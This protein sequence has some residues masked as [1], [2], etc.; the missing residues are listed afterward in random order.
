MD[1]LP[2]SELTVIATVLPVPLVAAKNKMNFL[3][4]FY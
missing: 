1:L 2:A 3:T 4:A